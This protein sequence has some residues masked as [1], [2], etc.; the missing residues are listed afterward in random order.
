MKIRFSVHGFAAIAI[1][2]L[3]ASGTVAVSHAAEESFS[4]L[5]KRLK[6]EKPKFAKRQ[7][8][9]LAERYDLANRPAQGV[10][11]TKGKPATAPEIP[12]ETEVKKLMLPLT[13]AW[14]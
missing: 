7:Q 9:L 6:G 1:A 3:L 8:A 10:T 12:C 14:G 13:T 2:A 5:V 4:D 11:M